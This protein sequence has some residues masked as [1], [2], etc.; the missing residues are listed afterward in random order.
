M[1]LTA[2]QRR[3]LPRAAFG[4][5]AN[6]KLPVPT[7]EYYAPAKARLSQ[8]FRRREYTAAERNWIAERIDA[9]AAS[10]RKDPARFRKC[11]RRKNPG[12][13]EPV[14]VPAAARAYT[15][16]HWGDRPHGTRVESF[17]DARSCVPVELGTLVEAV[18]L[19][20]KGKH[21]R[22]EFEHHFR[23]PPRLYYGDGGLLVAGRVRVTKRG[24]EQ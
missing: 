17:P 13:P 12:L 9:I 21:V 19:T 2:E 4:D 18:Y 1:R 20:D 24:I 7:L 10:L 6:R 15:Q 11:L 22:V 14:D 3:C 5:P 8:M 16:F 23:H